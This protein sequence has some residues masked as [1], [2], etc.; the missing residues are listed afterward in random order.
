MRYMGKGFSRR[1]RDEK[2]PLEALVYTF[3]S[4]TLVCKWAKN[5]A[6]LRE[7]YP[8]MAICLVDDPVVVA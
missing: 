2:P 7:E 5:F 3:R 8:R 4:L 1:Q 6:A